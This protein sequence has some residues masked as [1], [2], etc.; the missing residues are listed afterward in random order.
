MP[1][2]HFFQNPSFGVFDTDAGAAENV[3]IEAPDAHLANL[4]ALKFGI[5]FDGVDQGRDCS[6]CGDRWDRAYGDGCDVPCFWDSASDPV[7]PRHVANP[8]HG[9]VYGLDL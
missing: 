8:A 9:S 3:W 4:R 1:Y 5:Y 7:E 2:F 6:C